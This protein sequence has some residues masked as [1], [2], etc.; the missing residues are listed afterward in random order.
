MT[1][2]DGNIHRWPITQAI[3]LLSTIAFIVASCGGGGGDSGRLP[4]VSLP[5]EI[6]IVPRDDHGDAQSD[7]TMLSFDELAPDEIELD[8]YENSYQVLVLG[9]IEPGDDEDFFGIEVAEAGTLT[10][11]TTGSL[12]T[13]GALWASDVSFLATDD[14]SGD[15]NNFWIE[16]AVDPGAYYFGVSSYDMATGEYVL[17]ARFVVSPPPSDDDHGNSRS[18]ATAL[19]LGSSVAGRIETGGDEDF[20]AV[21]VTEPGALTVYTAGSLDTVGE[22][23]RGDGTRLAGDDDSGGQDNFRI[24]HDVG[25]GTYYVKVGSYSTATGG[26]VVLASFTAS[27]VPP[28]DDHGDT[29]SDA[30]PLALG[31]SVPGEIEEGGDEDFFRVEVP[32]PGT[33]A[34]Y[35]TGSL[36]TVGEL[37]HGDG[38]LLAGDDDSGSQDN[39]RIEHDVG[40]GHLLRQGRQFSPADRNLYGVLGNR[41]RQFRH[42]RG[43]HQRSGGLA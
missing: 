42:D 27:S 8:D 39:F 15:Q 35:T 3:V 32:E 4:M 2:I 20:F 41:D 10:I 12:D 21:E 19:A 9:E 23:Q 36:D 26:Y 17:V 14:D 7:A 5:P 29:R 18:D 34:V 31:G 37:K 11:Y 38:T 16:L 25:A 43:S 6:P 22:L 30:S 24:E 33:L 28:S 40:G 1:D 13:V